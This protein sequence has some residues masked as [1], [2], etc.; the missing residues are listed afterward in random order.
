MNM[1]VRVVG[2]CFEYLRA[3]HLNRLRS[4]I[5]EFLAS[6]SLLD[7]AEHLIK[8]VKTLA[9]DEHDLALRVTTRVLDVAGNQVVDI[10]TSKALLEQDLVQ[11]PLTVYTHSVDPAMKSRAMDALEQLLLLD[12]RV[13]QEALADWDR[14]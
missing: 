6:P 11:L 13:A 9:P 5:E 14:R 7:S 2:E 8:Y 3:E 1:S 10:R 4:F 12:S